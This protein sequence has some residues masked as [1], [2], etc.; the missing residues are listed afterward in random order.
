MAT[1]TRYKLVFFAPV[2][3]IQKCKDAIFAVGAGRYPGPGDYTHCGFSMRG[4]GQFKPGATANP[5]IGSAGTTHVEEVEEIRFET[6]CV[7]EQ[8]VQEAVKELKKYVIAGQGQL[9]Q[10]LGLLI[11]FAELI[12]MKCQ[13]TR[14][15]SWRTSDRPPEIGTRNISII[16]SHPMRPIIAYRWKLRATR[17][18]KECKLR[19]ANLHH[20]PIAIKTNSATTTQSR[21]HIS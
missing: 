9:A 6:L 3:A 12:R 10:G 14:S 13:R 4:I 16:R 2:E 20:Q 11:S 18:N 17:S 8:T 15:T 7:G 21:Q 1:A 5:H 19:L